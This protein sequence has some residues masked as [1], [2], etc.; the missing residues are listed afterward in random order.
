[1]LSIAVI[2]SWAGW[3]FLRQS[4][5]TTPF[6]QVDKMWWYAAI[7]VCGTLMAGYSLAAIWRAVRG[8]VE[9]PHELVTLS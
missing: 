7:P 3:E 2:L 1:M 6:L 9:L 4:G 5:E 8:Q